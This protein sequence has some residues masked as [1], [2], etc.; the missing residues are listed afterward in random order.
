[1]LYKED[2]GE[3]EERFKAYWEQE[4]VDRVLIRVVAPKK[5]RSATGARDISYKTINNWSNKGYDPEC[6][7]DEAEQIIASTYYGG[8]AIPYF[9]VNL[10]PG[11]LASYLGCTANFTDDTVWF[12]P[13]VLKDWK[14]SS[15]IKFNHKNKIW[16]VTKELTRFASKRGKDKFL[17]SFTDIGGVMDIIAS[18]VGTEKLCLDLIQYP[19]KVKEIRDYIAKVWI[20]CYDELFNIVKKNQR[21]TLGWL[22][23]WSPGKTYP[24]QSGCVTIQFFGISSRKSPTLG[25]KLRQNREKTPIICL[26]CSFPSTLITEL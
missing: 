17:V 5:G 26:F 23:A 4:I 16:R 12:G 20:G 10:G 18:L 13:P 15:S 19:D 11:S 22:S 7:V 25:L 14:L 9:W 3:T 6:L 2:W 8:E 24:L 1:M 21:G